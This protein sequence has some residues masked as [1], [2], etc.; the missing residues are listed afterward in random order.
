MAE[1]ILRL[2]EASVTLHRMA[3]VCSHDQQNRDAV[4]L[5]GKRYDKGLPFASEALHLER[6]RCSVG[7]QTWKWLAW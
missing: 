3:V 6:L 2:D 5:F 7:K 4:L 1:S